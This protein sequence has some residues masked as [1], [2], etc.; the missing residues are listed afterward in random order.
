M[1]KENMIPLDDPRGR[2]LRAKVHE[3]D[4]EITNFQ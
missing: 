2:D 1:V 3:D 4:R